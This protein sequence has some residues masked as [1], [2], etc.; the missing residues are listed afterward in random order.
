MWRFC[1]PI[2][3]QN[4]SS[5]DGFLYYGT[6]DGADGTSNAIGQR[7]FKGANVAFLDGYVKWLKPERIGQDKLRAGGRSACK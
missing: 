2:P 6:G 7:H 5:D 4:T 3:I 1:C